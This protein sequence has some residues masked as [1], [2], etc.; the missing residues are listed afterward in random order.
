MTITGYNVYRNH[1]LIG[2]S[3]NNGYIDNPEVNYSYTYYVTA[4][5]EQDIESDGSNEVYAGQAPVEYLPPTNLQ[6]V[7][8]GNGANRRIEL[9]WDAPQSEMAVAEYNIYRDDSF[10]QSTPQTNF[11]DSPGNNS[12]VTYYV[13]AIYED[14]TESEP[15]E[16]ES[17]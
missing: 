2:N 16:T 6:I 4:V 1:E 9:S 12:T 14:G 17:S 15:S 11:T 3:L 13:T 10:I 8:R 5:Y 7:D